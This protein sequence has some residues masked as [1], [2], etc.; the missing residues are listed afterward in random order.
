MYI[1][2]SSTFLSEEECKQLVLEAVHDD[3]NRIFR[4]KII[5]P[6]VKVLETKSGRD[7]YVGYG[8]EFLEANAEMLSKE[9]PTKAVTF[10]FF[11]VWFR[12]EGIH[13]G[14]S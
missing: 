2:E 5:D 13:Q 1:A 12:A 8:S 3:S 9:Y 4:E 11:D 6:I 14:H 10:P 7:K